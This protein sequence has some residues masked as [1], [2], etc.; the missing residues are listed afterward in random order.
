M[1]RFGVAAANPSRYEAQTPEALHALM[2]SAH[3]VELAS[4]SGLEPLRPGKLWTEMAV[5]MFMANINQPLWGW[6]DHQTAL[7]MDFWADFDPQVRFVVCYEPPQ[8]YL[9]RAL[10]TNTSPTAEEIEGALREWS[11]WNSYL[12]GQFQRHRDRSLLVNSNEAMRNPAKVLQLM[13]L[14]WQWMMEET[15]SEEGSA[16]FTTLAHHLARNF[17]SSDHVCWALAAKLEDEAGIR[18]GSPLASVDGV[19]AA[20]ADWVGIRESLVGVA[21]DKAQLAE[22]VA[23]REQ[24][25]AELS[26]LRGELE[27]LRATAQSAEIEQ[28][29]QLI[30]RLTTRIESGSLENIRAAELVMEN[31]HLMVALHQAQRDVENLV[32]NSAGSLRTDGDFGGSSTEDPQASAPGLIEDIEPVDEIAVDMRLPFEGANWY[33]AEA[34]GRWAGPGLRSSIELPPLIPG[35][36]ELQIRL[37]DAIAP[38]VVYGLRIEAFG[39]DVPF[40]LSAPV[41]RESY[42]I[43][44]MATFE[45]PAEAAGGTWPLEFSFPRTISPAASGS[46]DARELAVRMAGLQLTRSSES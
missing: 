19:N 36:Y 21:A 33:G 25:E 17:I 15:G 37:V 40:E 18:S 20:W 30:T 38:D 43:T 1:R 34:D 9:A 29:S 3:D 42:P 10:S 31:E 32:L 14:E 27:Q 35:K 46:S 13:G 41:T 44:C 23:L 16:L 11:R 28:V 12:M 6:A 4:P 2:L 45:A 8:A 5:D 22:L 7:A 26:R 39:A 24:D